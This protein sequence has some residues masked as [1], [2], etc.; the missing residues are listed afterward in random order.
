MYFFLLLI[1]ALLKSGSSKV[2]DKSCGSPVSAEYQ[3]SDCVVR[4]TYHP[5]HDELVWLDAINKVA[6]KRRDF[7]MTV[8]FKAGCNLL[9][10]NRPLIEFWFEVWKKR[11]LSMTCNE[12]LSVSSAFAGK[13]TKVDTKKLPYFLITDSCRPRWK[14]TVVIEPLVGFLRHPYHWC[15]GNMKTKRYV[16]SKDYLMPTLDVEIAPALGRGDKYL[17]FDLGCSVYSQR[18][19]I[20][21]KKAGML[22]KGGASQDWFVDEYR[23]RGIDFD[24]IFAWEVEP[25]NPE[26]LF[27]GY[28][29]DVLSKLS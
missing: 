13:W 17:F 23:K 26:E 19:Y 10:K 3:S 29:D 12:R 6:G 25:Q 14:E 5:S 4:K 7:P 20:E 1:F 27:A 2:Y 8:D 21:G 11:N 28:P 9:E 18:Y 22:E 15:F 24:R 16:V